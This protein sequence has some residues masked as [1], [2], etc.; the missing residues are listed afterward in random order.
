MECDVKEELNIVHEI[1]YQKDMLLNI[2]GITEKILGVV[3]GQPVEEC[4]NIQEEICL[5]DTLKNNKKLLAKLDKNIEELAAK[6][7]G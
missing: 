7:I 2:I 3:R 6:I 1:Q 4:E 5:L